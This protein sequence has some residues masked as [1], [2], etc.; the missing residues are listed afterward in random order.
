MIEQTAPYTLILTAALLPVLVC[1]YMYVRIAAFS[2]SPRVYFGLIPVW[3]IVCLASH[4][5]LL[6]VPQHYD[7]LN[8]ALR[9]IS[10][11]AGSLLIF[12]I[13]GWVLVSKKRRGSSPEGQISAGLLAG[14]LMFIP[15][16]IVLGIMD[17]ALA[18][19]C[20]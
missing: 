18:G 17:C 5:I 1:L 4:I 16:I 15:G 20:L 9:I 8:L 13:S 14:L 2:G 3:P 10:Y 6:G 7:S 12:A 11:L 19:Y